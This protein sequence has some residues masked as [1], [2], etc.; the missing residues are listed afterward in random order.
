[1]AYQRV[2]KV[3]VTQVL[4]IE[5]GSERKLWPDLV[6]EGCRERAFVLGCN[7]VMGRPEW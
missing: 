5:T 3:V 2:A 1:M 7:T 4:N 6:R